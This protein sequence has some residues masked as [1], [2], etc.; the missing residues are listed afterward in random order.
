MTRTK[1]PILRGHPPAAPLFRPSVA[2]VGARA[3]RASLPLG[4]LGLAWVWSVALALAAGVADAAERKP[5]EAAS[6]QAIEIRGDTRP[7]AEVTAVV[8]VQLEK[9]YHVHSN[10]PSQPN[11]IATVLALEPS[12]SAKPGTPVYP[13]GKAEKVT[14]LD[15]PLSIYGE[16]FEI[17]VPLRLAA[18]AALPITIPVVLRYQA[19]QGPQC[20]PPARLKFDL[21][22]PAKQ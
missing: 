17:L 22:V 15:K 21:V 19:C 11:F 20:F 9:G 10:K 2:A 4:G 16:A 12:R 6:I 5:G 14:G 13:K 7:G 1:P 3:V 8:K 18:D